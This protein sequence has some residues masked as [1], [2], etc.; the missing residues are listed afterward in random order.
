MPRDDDAQASA[1]MHGHH[2]TRR[3]QTGVQE[4]THPRVPLWPEVIRNN[5]LQRPGWPQLD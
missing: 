1:K 4:R 5:L 3:D 2:L